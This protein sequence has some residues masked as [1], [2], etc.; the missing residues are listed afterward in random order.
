MPD[1]APRL[2]ADY[3]L[4][5]VPAYRLITLRDQGIGP[6]ADP[7]PIVRQAQ[8]HIAANTGYELYLSCAQDLIPAAI[9]VEIWTDQPPDSGD[10]RVH[11]VTLSPPTLECSSGELVLGSPTGEAIG[12]KVTEPGIYTLRIS[13]H[14]R[15][16]ATERRDQLL[17]LHGATT[18]LSA[19]ADEYAATERYIIQMWQ[20]GALDANGD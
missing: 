4:V 17:A 20:T 13:H 8:E 10:A 7:G 14:G 5:T 6:G 1:R 18:N 16:D 19:A 11:Q 15:I 9:R 12:V 3:H 2:L